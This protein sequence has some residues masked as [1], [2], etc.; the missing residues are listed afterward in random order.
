MSKQ[1]KKR[2][3]DL[4]LLFFIP[5]LLQA[6]ISI[7]DLQCEMLENPIGIDSRK[8][9]FSWRIFAP[10][11]RNVYQNSYHI[12][13]AST[14]EQLE[15]NVGDMWNS[16]RI[17]SDQS[18][19]IEYSGKPLKSNTYYYWKVRV[20]TNKG[21][22]DWSKP[23][24]WCMGLLSEND[25]KSQ[26]IGMDKAYPW[27]SETQ[28]SRLS[29]RYLRKE[30]IV[31]KKI[32]QAMVHI[33]GL[34]LYELY[35]NGKKISDNVLSPAS[36][37][38]R[39]TILYNSFD[40]TSHIQNDRNTIG[41]TLG[42]GRFYA[43]RQAYKPYKINTFGYPKMRLTLIID[44]EDGTKAV[45]GSD[46][47][48]KFTADGP[49]RSNN[50]YDGEEYDARK[51]LPGW[52]NI[53]YDDSGWE[54]A[55]RVSIPTGTLRAQIMPP[56]RVVEKITPIT[57]TKLSADKYTLDMGQN[58]VGWIRMKLKGE[59]GDTVKLRFAETLLPN[60]KLDTRNLR[61]AKATD[62]YILKGDGEEEWAPRFVYHGFRYVEIAGYHGKISKENFIGE[63]VNDDMNL[64][65]S[66]ECSHP[67][68]NQILKNAYWGIRGNYKGMPIDC[69]QRN[70]RQPW[71][72]DRTMGSLGESFIFENIHLYSKWMNDVR[73]AQR[74]DGCIPDV[75]PPF[76]N[77]YTDNVT[78]PAAFVFTGDM[79]YTQFGDLNPIKKNY[80]AMKKWLKHIK[81]EY[82]LDDDI[83]TCDKYG[84]WCV[85][86]E[87]PELIHSRDPKRQTDGKLLATAYY[88]KLLTLMNKFALLQDKKEDATF[89]SALAEKIKAGF[90][91]KFFN[92]D[93]LFYGNN[94]ATSNLLPLAFD[95][96]PAVYVPEIEKQIVNK[97]IKDHNGHICTGVIGSQWIL[98]E[99]AKMGRADLAFLLASN[100]T[101]PSWGYMVKKGATTIW[102][103]WNGD[104]ANPEMNS[105]NHVMLLGDFIPFC[106]Q[107]LAGIKSDAEEAGF[108]KIMMEPNFDIQ[109]LSYVKASYKTPY[110]EIKSR[111]KKNFSRLEWH[112]SVPPNSTAEVHFPDN[113]LRINESGKPIEQVEGI[114]Q[115]DKKNP[116]V[117]EIGSG[118]YTFS[119]D[120]NVGKGEWREGIVEEEF[121]YEKASFPE[122]HAAT[123][124]ETPKGLISAFF[125]GTKEGKSDCVI[126]VCRKTNEGWTKPQEVANGIIND[127]LRKACWNPVLFQ[128]PN[129]EL[130]L[131]Y[132]VGN[133]VS[134]WTG[135]LIRSYDNGLTW[136]K[137]ENLP[138]GYIG[139]SKNK[140]IMIHKKI[141]CPSSL[142]GSPGWRVH[143]EIT[144]NNGKSWRRIGPINDVKNIQ[145]IQP[146]ILSYKDSTFQVLCRTR[147]RALG[148]S[149]SK[150]NGET[151]SEMTLTDMPNN[152]S[153]IDAVTLTDGRQ[154]LV[155]NHVKPAEGMA[156]GARTPLNVSLSKDGKTWYASLILED[157]PISQYSYPSV[158]QGKD[159]FVHVVYTWRR[160]RIKYI[161]IDPKK[162]T[163][164]EIKDEMWPATKNHVDP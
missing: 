46:T 93:S 92:Q 117:C 162:L 158:I 67:M 35:V 3:A 56:M 60:G 24:F 91:R 57:I 10:Q 27:D 20:Q 136:T 79:I 120:L 88:Y 139:P 160:Q 106:Y 115:P 6:A 1:T 140:P 37:D 125:G 111:W 76:W 78:W 30:F 100:E 89:F 163:V 62:I 112:I 8:P 69:P 9:R 164:A 161:K 18:Q 116:L 73:E 131:F 107:H 65:G 153:G 83:I 53:G 135:H 138:E 141:I 133:S 143:F 151:W 129:G 26:W 152:N 90:N 47:S 80:R 19:W 108:K 17:D 7:G 71:L 15:N 96:V 157:S 84:D 103:L 34:G 4:V 127:T 142:E 97:I 113:S 148:E 86:P 149:W 156:K 39:K 49:I 94:S 77:Y 25:W 95:M 32:N 114:R 31:G 38:Y 146:T 82:M 110:G 121:L 61:D 87:S 126:W 13:V 41:I 159:G 45:I 145:A 132:K 12:L 119:I 144:E 22:T 137:A 134:D 29:A 68:I 59:Q 147:N 118:E 123:I 36:T 64:I 122:C 58:M 33:A 99:L 104:T 101:Y 102:E 44:Y 2:I 48:W 70:E 28:F 85:P 50:E 109:E 150:D 14:K 52:N 74:E 130:L 128:I 124:A 51:E 81:E 16:G 75:A 43:M 5:M 21:K 105:H 40:V 155:Y 154:L 11:E 55:Q 72:G 63:V 42:N 23:A 98:R 66:F 54:D